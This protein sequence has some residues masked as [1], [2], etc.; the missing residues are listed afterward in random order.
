MALRLSLAL[1]LVLIALPGTALGSVLYVGDSLGVGTSPQLRD[2]LGSAGLEV[3]VATGRPSGVGVDVLS[4]LISS[5][6]DAVIFDLGTNDDPGVPEELAANLTEAARIADGRCLVV[7]TL[8]RP[9]LNGVAVDGLN[10][11]VVGLAREHDNVELVDWHGVATE[12]PDLLI[13]GVHSTGEGYALRAGL[14][15]DAV[16]NCLELG[17]VPAPAPEIDFGDGS[18]AGGTNLAPASAGDNDR[19]PNQEADETQGPRR[20]ES[21]RVEGLA[22]EVARAVGTGAEFG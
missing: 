4:G 5:E 22:G 17:T 2:F 6:H 8:N 10:R 11:A 3:D 19:R 16:G 9:P 12:N 18:T 14:F 21:S 15:A 20:D 13:D 7:A 1:A